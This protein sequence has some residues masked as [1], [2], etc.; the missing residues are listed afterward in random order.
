MAIAG[1]PS[2]MAR[3]IADGFVN[4]SPPGL[5]QY[6]PA[7]FK[8]ILNHLSLASRDLRQEVIPAENIP[9]IKARNMKLS[10]LN[11]A[12]TVIRAFCKK[13]RIPC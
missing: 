12:A 10:R 8:T 3:D 6:T 1:S 9:A 13:H 2:K 4:L 5:K 11:Q 7:D